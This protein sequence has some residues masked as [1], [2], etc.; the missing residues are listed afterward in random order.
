MHHGDTEDTEKN[1][2]ECIGSRQYPFEQ[3]V[4][5]AAEKISSAYSALLMLK[6]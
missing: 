3:E 5:E 1:V 4:A 6:V 2:F